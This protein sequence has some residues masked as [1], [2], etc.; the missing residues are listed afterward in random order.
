MRQ[1]HNTAYLYFLL[2]YAILYTF[3]RAYNFNYNDEFYIF[4][5]VQKDKKFRF[6]ER[7]KHNRN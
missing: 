5:H 7:Q 6:T 1:L 3:I 2:F 4:N